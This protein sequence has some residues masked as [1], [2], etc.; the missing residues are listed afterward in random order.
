MIFTLEL[1]ALQPKLN[2]T[3]KCTQ[4]FYIKLKLAI[5]F[6][7]SFFL[8]FRYFYQPYL[9]SNPH[10]TYRSMKVVY[11]NTTILFK[12]HTKQHATCMLAKLMDG[13]LLQYLDVVFYLIFCIFIF[14]YYFCYY[15]FLC[16]SVGV[17]I[18]ALY[19]LNIKQQQ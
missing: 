14:L 16:L 15:C 7:F 10:K 5:L 3:K 12:K 19:Y 1:L 18:F 11:C 9:N 4:N 8:Y 2:K 13:H 17:F 6:I